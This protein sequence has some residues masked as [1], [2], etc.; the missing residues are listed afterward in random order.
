MVAAEIKWGHEAQHPRTTRGR[1]PGMAPPDS[2]VGASGPAAAW[3]PQHRKSWWTALALAFGLLVGLDWVL[4]R[5]LWL[6]YFFGTFFFL[7]AGLMVG[8]VS[9]RVARGA[10]PL[11]RGRIVRGVLLLAS[12]SSFVT[13]CWEYRFIAAGAGAP[14][15]FTDAR[16]AALREG[17]SAT[18]V[19]RQAADAFRDGLA[20]HFAPGGVVGYVRWA[21]A[22]GEMR[23][24]V[25]DST[26]TVS[27]DDH[28]GF[29][30]PIRTI[31]A[32]LLLATGL[33]LSY[34]PLRSHQPISN[35]LAPGEAYEEID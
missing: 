24:K 33:W 19:L 11:T 20:V 1:I 13:I 14:P 15:K 32:L 5:L 23:I 16:N 28:R 17:R 35:V 25:A 34:E 4:A 27:I 22:S 2:S 3:T 31:V 29:V 10:R 26:E 21:I 9:F 30:W 7:I 6:P 18:E 8:A 12:L